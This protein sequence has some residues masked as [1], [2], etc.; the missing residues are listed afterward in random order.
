M[1]KPDADGKLSRMIYLAMRWLLQPIIRVFQDSAR[2]Y[3]RLTEIDLSQLIKLNPPVRPV[4][5]VYQATFL[6]TGMVS[7]NFRTIVWSE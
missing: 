3:A 7:Y 6:I 1:D 4:E 2:G 5:V